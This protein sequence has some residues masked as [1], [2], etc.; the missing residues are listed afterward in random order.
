MPPPKKNSAY[1]RLMIRISCLLPAKLRPVFLH[2][3]GPTTVFF[4]APTFKWG[5]VLAGLGDMK[6][7]PNTISLTQTASLMITGAI[8]SRYS[9][10]ITPKNYNLF[11]VNAF[12]CLTGMYN[13]IRALLYKIEQEK[14]EEKDSE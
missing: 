13:F 9:L 11:S 8:W 4:W 7:P 2:P 1:Q 3:A 12:T 10:I 5:L 14:A 6:R